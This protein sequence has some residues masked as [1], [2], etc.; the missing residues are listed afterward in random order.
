[1]QGFP[2]DV[3]LER[4]PCPN[5][6]ASSDDL[7][8]QGRDR[9]HDLPG[10][11]SVMRCKTCSL[12]RTDPRPTSETIGAYYPNDYGPYST[13]D[14]QDPT[15]RAVSPIKSRLLKLLGMPA[16]Q[17]PPM[18]PG[19]MLELGCANGAWLLEMANAGWQVEGIEFSA[20]AA[21]KANKKGLSVQVA[22]V[23]QARAPEESVDII[24]AWMVLEHLHQPVE[25]LRKL[26]QWVAPSGY[27]IASVPDASSL[28]FKIFGEYWY[29]L[30]LPTH[31]YHYTPSSI[32]ILLHNSGWEL[33]K[34]VWQRNCQNLLRS[35][36]YILQDRKKLYLLNIVRWIRKA[37]R[38]SFLRVLLNWLLGATRQSGRMEIWAQPLS[39]RGQTH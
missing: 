5:G 38:A 15:A 8:L 22:S 35:L 2:E 21:E 37:P 13:G 33:K 34:V 6:C 36:E 12:M 31:Y 19:R 17:L 1:M 28:E 20:A 7:V 3:D 32:R 25:A 9:L 14:A 4:T 30:Q 39:H 23:E 16:R 27:L 11:F 26:R 29:A 18:K 10:S 24:A